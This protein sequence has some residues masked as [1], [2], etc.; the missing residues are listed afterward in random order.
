MDAKTQIGVEYLS[1][2]AFLLVATGIIFAVSLSTF[3]ETDSSTKA[4]N[5]VEEL[6]SAANEVSALGQGSVLVV[7]TDLPA[8]IESMTVAG[9][10][11]R[12][13]VSTFFGVREYYGVSKTD[14]SSISLNSNPPNPGPHFFRVVF[15]S[16]SV[17][18]EELS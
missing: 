11:V 12:I 13:A 2:T 3:Y 18:I 10:E 17:K 14:F 15:D 8:D 5:A 4:I 6:A 16:G 7:R 1:L 9:K